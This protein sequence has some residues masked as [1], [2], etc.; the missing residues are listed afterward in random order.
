M[1]I[2]RA[3]I[4]FFLA[5]S[6]LFY[7]VSN[8]FV[9][10]PRTIP[11]STLASQAQLSPELNQWRPEFEPIAVLGRDLGPEYGITLPEET[12]GLK[13]FLSSAIQRI[14]EDQLDGFLV[15][16][17]QAMS[18]VDS[19]WQKPIAEHIKK[20]VSA[21]PLKTIAT[22]IQASSPWLNNRTYESLLVGEE[23]RALSGQE[24]LQW[25][26]GLEQFYTS[27]A[28]QK[29]P[30]HRIRALIYLHHLYRFSLIGKGFHHPAV[31]PK[32][33]VEAFN[34]GE[35]ERAIEIYQQVMREQG[36][37]EALFTALAA[38]YRKLAWQQ[39]LE[40][41]QD[42]VKKSDPRN[43]PLFQT[44]SLEQYSLRI[45]E[46]FAAGD[47]QTNLTPIGQEESSVRA[48]PTKTL[49]SDI[50]FLAML[51]P[52]WAKV[53]NF[54][55][56]LAVDHSVGNGSED[57]TPPGRPVEVFVRKI[58]EPVIRLVS[59]DLK[60]SKDVESL[61]DLF[62][63]TS[64][65]LGL[66]KAAVI[67]SG[68]VPPSFQ[69]ESIELK[70]VLRRFLG[71]EGGIELVTY[72]HGIPK[73]SRLAVSTTLLS[74]IIAKLMRFSGQFNEQEGSLAE[75]ELRLLVSRTLLA[76]W[77]GGSGGGF[78][79]TAGPHPGIRTVEAI[80]SQPGDP[81]HGISRGRLVPSF[82]RFSPQEEERAIAALRESLVMVHGGLSQNVGPILQ[83]VTEEF[84]VRSERAWKARQGSAVLFPQIVEALKR[85]DMKE[86]GRLTEQDWE[87]TQE[88]IPRVNNAYTQTLL[89]RLKEHFGEDFWGF[90]MLG[91]ASTGGMSFLVNPARKQEFKKV[92]FRFMRELKD[93]MK[94][95]YPFAIDPVVYSFDVDREGIQAHVV[96]EG[97]MPREYYA[98]VLAQIVQ[99]WERSVND[100]EKTEVE[101][102]IHA[103]TNELRRLF[104][105]KQREREGKL[106]W[107]GEDQHRLL[108][109]DDIRSLYEI[110]FETTLSVGTA[111]FQLSQGDDQAVQE[112]LDLYGFDPESFDANVS[113]LEN[114]GIGVRQNRLPATARLKDIS[115]GDV[116]SLEGE[117]PG[118]S[119][120]TSP[121]LQGEVGVIIL[122][123][124]KGG[125][126]TGGEEAVKA[127]AEAFD[128]KSFM[129]I[130]LSSLEARQGDGREEN[131]PVAV[132]TSFLTDHQIRGW[133]S[134]QGWIEEGAHGVRVY[135]ST[136]RFVSQ[137]VNP[138]QI[139]LEFAL[140]E[141]P[142]ER[143]LTPQQ[144]K[145]QKDAAG[146]MIH[147]VDQRTEE[148]GRIY[149]HNTPPQR[150]VPPGH[151]YEIPSMMV[152]GALARMLLENPR[153]KEV[154]V[155]G[156]DVIGA[157]PT[158]ELIQ[159]HRQSGRVMS[160][161]VVSRWM[162]DEGS[163]LVVDEEGNPYYLPGFAMPVKG[164]E[165]DF[166]YYDSN[167]YVISI[168]EFLLLFG[169]T[170]RDLFDSL[171]EDE[172]ASRAK[173]KIL[174]GIRRVA[175][176]VPTYVVLKETAER[177]GL[178]QKDMYLTAQFEKLFGD[179]THPRIWRRSLEQIREQVSREEWNQVFL[180]LW[181]KLEQNGWRPVQY[182]KVNRLAGQNFKHVSEL[183]DLEKDGTRRFIGSLVR[184][185]QTET[186][187]TARRNDRIAQQL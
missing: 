125:R 81:E 160:G 109:I 38:G 41:V 120:Q 69:G 50:F 100:Q 144:R 93:Q 165:Y 58:K 18:R 134:R 23:G 48:D 149:R 71:E 114:G 36:P 168:D 66:L 9:D 6:Q 187:E 116:V 126:Y 76:E 63:F 138:T 171:G 179:L 56:F 54:S 15:A 99:R 84:L 87:L 83:E 90:V 55:S 19:Y 98:F 3:P 51:L 112:S 37:S 142:R 129:E 117:E 166:K 33:G 25:A 40:I 140:L 7:N 154:F 156:V 155:K 4:L 39:A 57:S 92:V 103:H 2:I 26:L 180:P 174:E 139:D 175:S 123:G 110:M 159:E 31:I 5:L 85:G 67:A 104:E 161:L 89:D 115:N 44:E 8:A 73:G 32:E 24:I 88:V 78:Q 107:S 153:M 124:G 105:R 52:E 185:D 70:E 132:T 59:L 86:L 21:R 91:G 79:D 111:G 158:D 20:E 34:E 113:A 96:T 29:N 46:V 17:A 170:R 118:V 74:A 157:V 184:R 28:A 164:M 60:T 162:G 42:A 68:I 147:W 172:S 130:N 152:N 176:L 122:A 95:G 82:N 45:A 77:L 94:D 150:L 127:L 43:G 102:W 137:K 181:E 128:G 145:I 135:F 177:W 169:L 143:A 16:L 173:E 30:Y 133:L 131:I 47:A 121:L 146:S 62:N 53:L 151:L 72:V 148:T 27:Q 75:E 22:V 163:A 119:S 13:A 14:P 64:D 106:E 11:S 108:D 97:L 182:I 10:L 49:W 35:S 186:M 1:K 178:G 65:Y 61:E 183:P 101:D 141:E 80:L 136:G 167:A 12:A